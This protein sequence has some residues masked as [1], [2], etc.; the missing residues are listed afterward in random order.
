[1]SVPSADVGELGP[2]ATG[3]SGG[4]RSSRSAQCDPSELPRQLERSFDDKRRNRL[5]LGTPKM[6]EVGRGVHCPLDQLE[7]AGELLVVW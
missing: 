3:V 1:M 4:L 2:A 7:G 6:P 5:L